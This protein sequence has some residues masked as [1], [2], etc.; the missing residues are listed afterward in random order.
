MLKSKNG[1]ENKASLGNWQGIFLITGFKRFGVDSMGDDVNWD[2]N[3][4]STQSGFIVCCWHTNRIKF[5]DL[6]GPMGGNPSR[7]PNCIKY[8]PVKLFS[9]LCHIPSLW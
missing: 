7:F 4:A 5:V 2:L 9:F 3:T 6:L 8:D 1:D